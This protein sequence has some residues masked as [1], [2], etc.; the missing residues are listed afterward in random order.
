MNTPPGRFPESSSA[1]PSELFGAVLK[2]VKEASALLNGYF[3]TNALNV[4]LKSDGT[5]VSVADKSVDRLFQ[6]RLP[7]LWPVPVVSEESPLPEGVERG[8]DEYWLLDP[9]DGTQNFLAGEDEFSIVLA[10]IKDG[11]S[12][13]GFVAAPAKNVIYG[14]IQNHGAW[15]FVGESQQSIA[16]PVTT[17][18]IPLR[19][20][21]SRFPKPSS[22]QRVL[23]FRDQLPLPHADIRQIGSAYKSMLLLENECDLVVSYD[24]VSLWDLGGVQCVLS[25]VGCELREMRTGGPIRF[26]LREG[27][28]VQGY[29]AYRRGVEIRFDAVRLRG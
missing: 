14:A 3:R 13:L 12:R 10:L 1:V 19:I 28:N 7:S 27:V 20:V 8:F 15:R 18:Q 24:G 17:D 9:L 16:S 11:A 22:L 29:F 6:T 21:T 25:E 26:D 23:T 5:P 2:L 4:E